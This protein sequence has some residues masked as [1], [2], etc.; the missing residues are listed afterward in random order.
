MRHL[1]LAGVSLLLATALAGLTVS[2]AA[3]APRLAILEPAT[4][5]PAPNGYPNVAHV[6]LFASSAPVVI[7]EQ[8]T[9]A[10]LLNNDRPKDSD[11]LS[12]SFNDLC[13]EHGSGTIGPS[14]EYSLAGGFRRTTLSWTGF[15]EITGGTA[16][17]SEPGPCVYD[18]RSLQGFQ[19]G[20]EPFTSGLV[21]VEGQAHGSLARSESSITCAEAQSL[22]FS[23][24][25]TS[26][27]FILGGE[28]RG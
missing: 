19:L 3:A 20:A 1:R 14:A 17:V 26:G 13:T 8:T 25:L 7:C 11:T 9:E 12:G 18:F 28:V 6:A 5:T 4:L 15:S 23:A 21:L 10:M 22:R 27:E 16:S 2:A 24:F